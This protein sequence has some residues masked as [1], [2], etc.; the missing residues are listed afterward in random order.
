MKLDILPA[1]ISA[2]LDGK[3]VKYEKLKAFCKTL[4]SDIT[5]NDMAGG[6]DLGSHAKSALMAIQMLWNELEEV[7]A[8]RDDLRKRLKKYDLQD[9]EREA[10]EA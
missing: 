8:E 10:S 9:V 6:S 7:K 1:A 3:H 5:C 2:E 4:M